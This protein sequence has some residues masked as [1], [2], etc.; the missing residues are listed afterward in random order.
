MTTNMKPNTSAW[1]D[2]SEIAG[3]SFE[4]I[5]RLEGYPDNSDSVVYLSGSLVEGTGNEWSDIDVFVIGDKDPIGP[6]LRQADSYCATQHFIEQKRVDFEF[7][8][9][10]YVKQLSQRLTDIKLGQGKDILGTSFEYVEECFIHRIRVGIPIV[11]DKEFI[12]FQSLFNFDQ[13]QAYQTEQAIRYLDGIHED[14]CGA[15]E[16]H[17]LEVALFMG[18]EL[19][20]GAI[21]AYCHKL[22]NTDP[23]RKWRIKHL[24]IFDDGSQRHQDIMDTFWRLQFPD[25]VALRKDRSACVSHLEECVHFANGLISWIQT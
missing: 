7:W 2:S 11:N 6:Y 19:I 4:E 25:A 13:F 8:Q 12:S 9:P 15:I 22:G 21:D 16:S 3:I 20:E 18:R 1:V 24:S 5:L 14:I 17:D 23:V 10:E